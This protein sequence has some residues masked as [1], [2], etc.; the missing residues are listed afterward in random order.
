M[1]D[2]E[3]KVVVITGSCEGIGL[4]I[5]KK[6]KSYNSKVVLVYFDKIKEQ[7]KLIKFNQ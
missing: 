1:K 7:K 2:L 4:E 3:N 5:A 6:F